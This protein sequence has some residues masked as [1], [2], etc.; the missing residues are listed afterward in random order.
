MKLFQILLEEAEKNERYPNHGEWIKS[1]FSGREGV[2][3][4]ISPY[5]QDCLRLSGNGVILY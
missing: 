3:V 1:G 4:I 5:L 2:E